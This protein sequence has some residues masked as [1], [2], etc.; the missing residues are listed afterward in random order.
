MFRMCIERGTPIAM[1]LSGG[2]QKDSSEIIAESISN[3]YFQFS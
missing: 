3:L 2:Y 1:L